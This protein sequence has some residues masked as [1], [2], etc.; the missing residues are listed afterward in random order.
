MDNSET[1][2]SDKCWSC[3][4]CWNW[5]NDIRLDRLEIRNQS[6]GSVQSTGESKECLSQTFNCVKGGLGNSERGIKT[7]LTLK[8]DAPLNFGKARHVPYALKPNVEIAMC[9]EF[10]LPQQ[11]GVQWI[12]FFKDFL[13]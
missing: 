5:L 8:P 13:E 9:I 2:C 12:R 4:V 11:F 10:F 7:K 3:T 6:S 1:I